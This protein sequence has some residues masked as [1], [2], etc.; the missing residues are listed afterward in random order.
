[1]QVGNRLQFNCS[2]CGKPIFFS[3]LNSNNAL[4]SCDK[5]HKKYALR[6]DTIMQDL[7]AFEALCY[8]IHASKNIL[9]NTGVAVDI[10]PYHVNIPFKLLLTRFTSTM[11]LKIGNS[12]LNIHFRLEPVTEIDSH[13]QKLPLDNIDFKSLATKLSQ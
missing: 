4:L 9:G 13:Q 10:G 5:C 1:M 12:D 6:E 7:R 11:E 8:Q 2:E 3:V